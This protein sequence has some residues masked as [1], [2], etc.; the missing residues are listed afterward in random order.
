[1]NAIRARIASRALA[2]DD[3]LPSIRSFAATMGVAPSTVVEAYDRLA[4]EGLIRA[5]PGS[6]FYVSSAAL[7]PLALTR[8]QPQ[9]DRAVDPFWVSRQSLDAASG[10]LKPGCGWL[11]A[12]WMPTEA[13]RRAFRGLARADDAVL[14]DYG[15]TRGSLALRRMLM[16]RFADEGLEVSPEQVLLTMSGTQAI[17][18]ICRFLLR[19]GDTVLVDDP[20]YFNFRA[21]LRAHQVKLISVPY[22]PS[23]PDITSFEAVLDAERPRL[24]ITVSGLHNPTGATMSPQTAHRVLNA[25]AAFDLTIVEDDIFTDFEPEPS[26]RLAALDGLNRVIRIGSFSKTLSASL[27]CGFIAARADWIEQLVD[28]QV[29]TGFG[30]PCAVATE[31]IA[32]VLATGFYRKHVEELRRRLARARRDVGEKLQRI[33]IEPWLM[34]RGGFQLWCRLPDGCDSADVARA[35]LADN[36]VLAPGNVFSTTQSATGFMRFN[37]AQ[38]RDPKLM[39]ALQRAI[40]R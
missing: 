37:V 13:L 11:P 26:A 31:I 16:A 3:R 1:M 33:G 27:R 36:I 4:A 35:A 25:A 18:L 5:R 23:G 38:C 20:C 24:Y 12:D 29:A 9:H 19:P 15:A 10:A 32:S 17:D 34:P 8:D 14:A 28:L 40:G 22:T 30:G 21:L 6:G 2:A 7:P 39:P